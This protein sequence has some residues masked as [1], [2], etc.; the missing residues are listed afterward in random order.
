MIE[1]EFFDIEQQL[2][3]MQSNNNVALIL[4]YFINSHCKCVGEVKNSFSHILFSKGGLLH[5]NSPL[6]LR[7]TIHTRWK[8]SRQEDEVWLVC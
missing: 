8:Y 4:N 3:G 1:K 5:L 7:F 6:L 2:A